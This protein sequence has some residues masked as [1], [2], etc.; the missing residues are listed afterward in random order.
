MEII[1]SIDQVNASFFGSKELT[2]YQ[3][4]VFVYSNGYGASKTVYP[5]E[6]ITKTEMKAQKLYTKYTISI[7]PY[8]YHHHDEHPSSELGK[9]FRINL[10]FHLKVTN[11]KATAEKELFNLQAYIDESLPY[12]IKS[13]T[14]SYPIYRYLEVEQLIKKLPSESDMEFEL[15]ERGVE[16]TSFRSSLTIS[17][18]DLEFIKEQERLDRKFKILEQEKEK[19]RELEKK[20]MGW[21]KE[22]IEATRDLSDEDKFRTIAGKDVQAKYYEDKLKNDQRIQEEKQKLI[23][24][25]L[26]DSNLEDEEKIQ[27]IK[28]MGEVPEKQQTFISN[29]SIPKVGSG[30]SI[31]KATKATIPASNLEDEDDE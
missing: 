16:I 25:I 30:E 21:K 20:E 22:D 23:N 14:E 11:P 26:L 31:F 5:G 27:L 1:K 29:S 10:D 7:L 17:K 24:K 8:S 2:P 4:E 15:Q 13:V 18:E 19:A 12:W 9:K 28:N 6:R 3:G